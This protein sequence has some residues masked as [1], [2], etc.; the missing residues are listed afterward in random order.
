[1]KT[2]EQQADDLW[3]YDT[4]PRDEPLNPHPETVALASP[5]GYSNAGPAAMPVLVP[6]T[7]IV[8]W[9]D[10]MGREVK[11]APA[12]IKELFGCP[13]AT[14]FELWAFI[15]LCQMQ[16]LN[17]LLREVYLIKYGDQKAQIV[18]G[19]EHY[20]QRAESPS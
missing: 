4:E 15:Q 7:E 17:P 1:M 10:H 14:D 8:Q 12:C 3:G 16:K 19:K 13:G 20:T 5:T 6:K 18:L 2:I 11:I 9:T